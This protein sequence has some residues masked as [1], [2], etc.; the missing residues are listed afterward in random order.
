[1][2]LLRV[3]EILRGPWVKMIKI[4]ENK[5][6]PGCDVVK[7]VGEFG[8][9]RTKK[10]GLRTYC[11]G[12]AID[13][14]RNYRKNNQGSVQEY[15]RGYYKENREELLRKRV[16]QDKEHYAKN[17]GRILCR[18]REYRGTIRGYLKEVFGN[19]N[20][21]CNNPIGRNACYKGVQNRFES[22]DDFR[23]YVITELRVDPRSLQIDRIDSEGH[24]EKG[25]IRFV[26]C[27]E[28]SNNRRR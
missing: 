6:C 24:Y 20:Y 28:N 11:R 21:R 27:K 23:D 16:G 15:S 7:P 25:N 22:L 12:C 1:M 17:R 19:I 9:D 5:N 14:S 3:T 13:Y 8:K 4:A 2:G 10:D 18:G 26:T